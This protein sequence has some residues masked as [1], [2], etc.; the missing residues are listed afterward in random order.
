M[1]FIIVVKEEKS[2]GYTC[3]GYIYRVYHKPVK[4]FKNSLQINFTTDNGI[5]Y[6]NRE[7]NSPFVQEKSRAHF[8][9]ICR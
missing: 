8:A 9:L 4:Q 7:R 6:T 1:L 3:I 5:S 2:F